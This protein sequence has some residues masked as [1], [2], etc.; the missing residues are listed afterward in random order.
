M[1]F[2]AP[3][4]PYSLPCP[5]K[6]EG[7]ARQAA[8]H[9]CFVTCRCR[10]VAP[11][12][13]PSRRRY[14]AGPRF[15]RPIRPAFGAPARPLLGS[16]AFKP[17]AGRKAR[18]SASSSRR[19]LVPAGGAPAPPG[20]GRSVHLPRA[21]AASGPTSMTPHDSALGGSDAAIIK[22]PRRAG[23]SSHDIVIIVLYTPHGGE[24]REARHLEPCGR[25]ILRDASLTRR[26]SG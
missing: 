1:F 3:G 20:R 5:S 19:V 13:A 23:I 25:P 26:S 15:R 11:L 4:R 6:N 12:G 10:H 16:H 7:M 21:G 9:T 2:A 22:P 17:Q 14:G 18:P 8:R 24:P